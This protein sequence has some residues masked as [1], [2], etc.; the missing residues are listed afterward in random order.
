[1]EVLDT[2]PTNLEVLALGFLA[3]GMA[4][5]M[6]LGMLLEIASTWATDTILATSTATTEPVLDKIWPI[7]IS[8]ARAL[9]YL[10][11]LA[12]S[13]PLS[14]ARIAEMRALGRGENAED[15]FEELEGELGE[16]ARFVGMGREENRLGLVGVD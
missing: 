12:A 14:E 9:F 15:R 16:L 8:A 5:E 3:V 7:I 1:M 4:V 13:V 10:C 6:A 11:L 2:A